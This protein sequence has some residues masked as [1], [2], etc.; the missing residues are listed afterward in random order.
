MAGGYLKIMSFWRTTDN[1]QFPPLKEGEEGGVSFATPLFSPT[2]TPSVPLFQRG[3]NFHSLGR[4]FEMGF[5]NFSGRSPGVPVGLK[6]LAAFFFLLPAGALFAQ[7]P[8][9]VNNSSGDPGTPGSFGWAV[10]TFNATAAAG[11]ITFTGSTN[12]TLIQPVSAFTQTVTFQGGNSNLLGITGQN[13]AESQLLFQQSFFQSNTLSLTNNGTGA[14][15]DA[16]VTAANWTMDPAVS[17]TLQAASGASTLAT[18]GVGAAGQGGGAVSVTVGTWTLGN[19]VQLQ[20]GNGGGVTDTNGSGDQGGAGGAVSVNAVS[21]IEA[22]NL[23]Q[24]SGGLGGSVTDLGTTGSSKGGNGGSVSVLAN[25]V[26]IGNFTT[27]NLNGGGGGAGVTGGLGGNAFLSAAS[28][29]VVS[30]L[31]VQAGNGGGGVSVGGAGGNA[32]VSFGNLTQSAVSRYTFVSGGNGGAGVSI[33]GKGGG[34]SVVGNSV[35]L[36]NNSGFQV[37]GGNGAAGGAVGGNGGAA[38]VSLGSFSDTS[39]A[40]VSIAGGNGGAGGSGASVGTGGQGGNT[41]LF[42]GTLSVSGSNQ[43][44]LG[45][46]AGG[47]G[48]T[49]STPGT[50]GIGGAAGG[51]SVTLGNLI[52]SNGS[53]L[54]LAGNTGGNGGGSTGGTGGAGGNGGSVNL[55]IDA[56]T[57]VAGNF[58]TATGGAGGS[59]GTGTVL[60]SNGAQGQ[61]V[62]SIGT[63][64]GGGGVSVYGTGAQMIVATGTFLGSIQGNAFLEKVDTGALTLAGANTYSGNTYVTNGTLVVDTNGT[65][66]TGTVVN[67]NVLDYIHN[68]V[69]GSAPIT[70]DRT[71]NFM[72]NSSAGSA[73]IINNAPSTL[74]FYG[75]STGGT[76][77]IINNAGNLVDFSYNN[78]SILAGGPMTIGSIAG[79]GTYDLGGANLVTGGNNQSTTVSGLIT[80]GGG[81][82]GTGATL[83]KVGTGTMTLTAANAYSGGTNI[84]AGGLAVGNAQA[85]G[86]LGSVAMSGGTLSAAGA[87]LTFHVGGNYL[88]GSNGTLQLGLGGAGAVSQD[89]V[90]ISGFAGLNGTLSLTS[91]GSLTAMPVGNSVTVLT[92]AFTISGMFQQVDESYNGIRL[93]PL[94][95][96]NRVE[97]ESIIPSFQAVG[98]TANQK[99]VGADLDTIALKPQMNA[100]MKSIGVLSDADAEKAFGQMTPE[101]FTAVYQ[102]AFEGALARTALVNQRLDQLMADVDGKAW[103]PG[104]SS[105]GT[106][107]FAA[108]LSPAKEA[109]M[110]PKPASPWGGFIS[111]DGGFFDVSGDSNAA[112]YKVT[113]FGLT[114]AGADYRLSREAVVGLMVGYGHTDVN[115]GS[116]GS[117]TA[118]GGQVGL[119]GL[120]YSEGF[121]TGALVEGGLNSYSTQREGYGGTAAGSSQGSQFDGALELGYQFKAG[122]IHI[123]PMGLAQYSSVN[124]NAF[125]EQGSQA[126]LTVPNQSENSLLSR[127]G[128]KANGQWSMGSDSTFNPSLQLAWEHEYDYQGGTFQAG[129]GTGDSFT[130]AGPQIGQDGLLAGLGMGFTFAKS[131]TLSL[132]YQGEF[133]RTNLTSSQIG[134]G[135]KFGF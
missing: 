71:I 73:V 108:H 88:Q 30:G 70:N 3:M 24:L 11:A 105:A 32:S 31:N 97:L 51:L 94:Y 18:S 132:N 112:G 82:G 40:Y 28:V 34:A 78:A 16:S 15:L 8:V 93:L 64:E 84:E 117:L 96:S 12:P 72:D 118:E 106:P 35:S 76:A 4:H 21:L 133:G 98:T 121:Y 53:G 55:S 52:L 95:L 109:A 66:G 19:N 59:G 10:T 38:S 41:S 81:N 74:F 134:G 58:L 47:A 63:L 44:I 26:S 36:I 102:A 56:V 122:Q 120:F 48:G 125:T 45:G 83:T 27:V 69:A 91:Y 128:M 46:G 135:V 17:S 126:P 50:G 77:Q 116:G 42:L 80:D 104:F 99:A 85:L 107:W 87:P 23:L 1:T 115:L 90:S 14:G 68:S 75:N 22:D 13:E 127:L 2:N 110:S 6:L 92:S 114:G 57:M 29:S 33:G 123:G 20:A 89:A 103:L 130:V 43:I 65:L 100:L 25:F 9:T 124:L 61:A 62:V 101:D 39:N 49:N 86:T 67:L 129:F 111:G 37:T 5:K 79:A 113:T 54:T 60:G 119:Y 7:S 131:L